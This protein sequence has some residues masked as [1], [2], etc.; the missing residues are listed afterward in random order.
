VS[1]AAALLLGQDPSLRPEQV[2]WLLERGAD[3][4]DAATGCDSCPPERDKLTGWGTLDV[5]RSLS[6]LSQGTLPPVDHYEPNDNAGPWAHPLPPLPRTVQGTLDYWDDNLDVYRVY[7]R[8]GSGLYARVT[9]IGARS[10]VRM[11]VWAPGTQ[12]VDAL[13]IQAFRVAESR[14]VRSQSRVAYRA[15]RTGIYYLELRI[16]SPTFEPLSYRLALS[17]GL[18]RAS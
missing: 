7:M 5:E 13:D 3:D 9:P 11:S 16:A 6:L 10:G 8:K 14:T 17:R 1:A 15:T 4:A 2:A 12:R 18:V